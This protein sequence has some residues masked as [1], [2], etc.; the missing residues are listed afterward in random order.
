MDSYLYDIVVQRLKNYTAPDA[1]LT[2]NEIEMMTVMLDKVIQRDLPDA[3]NVTD[4]EE[5]LNVSLLCLFLWLS[6]SDSINCG[7]TMWYDSFLWF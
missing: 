4:A 3:L 2:K 7:D 5:D 1:Y 6:V